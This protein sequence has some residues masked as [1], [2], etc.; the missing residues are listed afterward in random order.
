MNVREDRSSK[1]VVLRD[2]NGNRQTTR[3]AAEAEATT[4][5]ATEEAK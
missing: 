4:A 5:P 1:N 2:A 3:P